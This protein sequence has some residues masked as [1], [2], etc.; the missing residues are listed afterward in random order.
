[1]HKPSSPQ[2]KEETSKTT[3]YND[4]PRYNITSIK[5]KL[6]NQEKWKKLDNASLSTYP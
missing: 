1:M 5:E 6:K 3:F 4:Q 2:K